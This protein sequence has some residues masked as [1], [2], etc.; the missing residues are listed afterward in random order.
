MRGYWL[1]FV[2]TFAA[3]DSGLAMAA[4]VPAEGDLPDD[5]VIAGATLA[6]WR[7]RMKNLNPN[8]PGAAQYV[9]GMVELVG[10]EQLPWFTRRQAALTMARMGGPARAAVPV[11]GKLLAR[12]DSEITQLWIL[13]AVS[14]F[15]PVAEELAPQLATLVRDSKQKHLLRTAALEALARIG[16]QEPVV[17]PVLLEGLRGQ[18]P[19]A[20]EQARR[21]LQMTTADVVSLLGPH[22]APALPDL[23]RL[24]NSDWDL[25][26]LSA[27]TTIGS[28]GPAAEI[29]IPTL[30][31]VILFDDADEVRD[32]AAVSLAKI[33]GRGLNVFRQLVTDEDFAVRSRVMIGLNSMP[34][35]P[36]DLLHSMLEDVDPLLRVQAAKKLLPVP[37]QRK[38]AL[39]VIYANMKS[40]NAQVQRLSYTTLRDNLTLWN[41]ADA[42]F[43]A[44]LTHNDQQTRKLAERLV[45][46][47]Q[48]E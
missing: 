23:I 18:L 41:P 42:A 38:R 46:L 36:I 19:A 45:A 7:T 26:R 20:N 15:G 27:V 35:P 9:P 3:L 5:T 31:D 24:C 11:L 8:D 10:N 22:A 13:K 28:S 4:E 34:S 48:T 6:D 21:E 47:R 17:I 44:L 14:L 43:S 30:G 32:A 2:L 16:P 25:I 12:E 39:E 37:E 29:A 40:Q 33:G 1:L